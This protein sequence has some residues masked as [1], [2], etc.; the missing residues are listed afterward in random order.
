[1]QQ[2]WACAAFFLLCLVSSSA[3]SKTKQENTKGDSKDAGQSDLSLATEYLEQFYDLEDESAGRPKR[4]SDSIRSKLKEMQRFFRLN[5]TGSLDNETIEVMKTPRCG[6]PDVHNYSP[7]GQQAKWHKNVISYSIGSYTRDLPASAVDHLIDSALKVWSSAS[8]LSFVRSYSQ[9]ADIRVQ[10]STYA[11]GD[12]F[13]FDGPGGT[14]AHAYGPGEGI[15]G[16]AHFD[17]DETWSAGF[18]GFNLYLVAAHEFGHALGLSHSRYKESLMY[19]TYRKRN[20]AGNILSSED[21]AK[22]Q[23]LYG[24]RRNLLYDFSGYGMT[25]LFYPWRLKFDVPQTRK[26]KCDPDLSFDAVTTLGRDVLLLKDRYLWIRHGQLPDIKEGPINNFMPRMYSDIDAAYS[27]PRRKFAYLFKGS[28]YWT[29]KGP[30]MKGGPKSIYKLGFPHQVKQI[31]AAVHINET[32]NTLF[33]IRDLYWSYNETAR[34]MEEFY[35]RNITD[36]FPG[37]STKTDAA[38][39][40]N[41]FLYFFSGSEVYKY[42][43]KQKKV[44]GT[45]KANTWLG[46]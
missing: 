17:D 2:L 12:F 40:K 14:L 46:C 34:A 1:M 13:P 7:N 15:G 37:I 23:A 3:V 42:D 27:L 38:V 24:P 19:P 16:D 25:S 26:E 30:E 29:V 4:S 31:D 35:P 45:E 32:G 10:F 11:H 5:E 43:Y 20:T 6:I 22:I 9:N 18:Q 28:K 44:S 21:V 39:E 36:D 41:G 33:F 8:P